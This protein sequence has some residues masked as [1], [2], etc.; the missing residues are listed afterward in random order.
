MAHRS[1]RA[2]AALK[3]LFSQDQ[4]MTDAY[5]PWLW[6]SQLQGMP[7]I[8]G[9]EMHIVAGDNLL[10]RSIASDFEGDMHIERPR[11][12]RHL[13]RNSYWYCNRS[14]VREKWLSCR[15]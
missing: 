5:R 15:A 1:T 10:T 4:E 6:Q 2:L 7:T 8:A 9:G 12:N 3:C 14:S 13:S 11:G